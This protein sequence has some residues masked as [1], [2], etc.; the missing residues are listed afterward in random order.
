MASLC[1]R[2]MRACC[3]LGGNLYHHNE[4][5]SW[6]HPVRWHKAHYYTL[7]LSLININYKL[8]QWSILAP[9]FHFTFYW[10]CLCWIWNYRKN[11]NDNKFSLDC[12][13]YPGPGAWPCVMW[14]DIIM[15]YLLSLSQPRYWLRARLNKQW[16]ILDQLVIVFIKSR[17]FLQHPKFSEETSQIFYILLLIALPGIYLALAWNPFLLLSQAQI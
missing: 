16:P 5:L 7:I 2:I 11:P 6:V 8:I 12:V 9:T 4:G 1:W 17:K 14:G 15:C 3:Q 10:L 13:C